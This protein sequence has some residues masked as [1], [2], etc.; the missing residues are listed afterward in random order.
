MALTA[1][2]IHS[3]ASRIKTHGGYRIVPPG[4]AASSRDDRNRHDYTGLRPMAQIQLFQ[5]MCLVVTSVNPTW[6]KRSRCWSS[7]D[8]G[9]AEA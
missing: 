2:P 9:G 5:S 4:T 8:A 7:L 6:M 1:E 3:N